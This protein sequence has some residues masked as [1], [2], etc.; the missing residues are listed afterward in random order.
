MKRRTLL[1]ILATGTAALAGCAENQDEDTTRTTDR[2]AATTSESV[3]PRKTTEDAPKPPETGPWGATTV[4]LETGDRTLSLLGGGTMLPSGLRAQSWLSDTATAD[5]PA[6]V[7]TTIANPTKYGTSLLLRGIGP[8]DDTPFGRPHDPDSRRTPDGGLYLVPTEN[9]EF[10]THEPAIARDDSFWYLDELPDDWHPTSIQLDPGEVAVAEQAIVTH[11]EYPDE[12]PVGR[13]RFGHG[14]HQSRLV[15]WHS[16]RPGPIESSRFA[17]S[18]PPPFEEQ[19][20]EWYH[21]A[22]LKTP[23]YLQPSTERLAAPGEVEFVLHNYRTEPLTGNRYDWTLYKEV[24]DTW[25]RIAPWAVV[26]PLTPLPPGDTFTWTLHAFNERAVPCDDA[27]NIGHLGGGNYAFQVNMHPEEA[28]TR[29]ALFDLEAPTIT[30][31][32]T[33]DTPS[34][35]DGSIV[36]VDGPGYRKDDPEEAVFVVERSDASTTERIIPE[37]VMRRRNQGLR[38]TLPFFESGV[39]R[40]ELHTDDQTVYESV[41]HDDEPR[42]FR[43]EGEPFVARR[44]DM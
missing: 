6:R 42:R 20:P 18:T 2:T 23:V 17:G 37:Q 22:D 31:T 21:D 11:Y 13:Y 32:P 10:A 14:D 29:A 3:D 44:G 12:F 39:E 36:T 38:N 33:A 24:D 40:V 43:F 1:S 19:A 7:T 16:T 8:L 9:H 28:P 27:I 35:R 30:V 5:H 4:V 25:Y 15:A 26:L 41:G 34:T